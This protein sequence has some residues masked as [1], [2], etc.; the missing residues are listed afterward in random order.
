MRRF[1][2]A[3]IATI[4]GFGVAAA[5]GDPYDAND[6][7]TPAGDGGGADA[8]TDGALDGD[9][10]MF[11]SGVFEPDAAPPIDATTDKP[12]VDAN[13][14]PCDCDGD[15]FVLNNV[16]KCPDAGGKRADCD[17]GDPR[18]F[19]DAG[20]R[21]DQPTT[22]TQGDWNC[23]GT[24]RRQY[25]VL[26]DCASISYFNC[27]GAQGFAVDPACGSA[28]SYVFCKRSG[29]ACTTGSSEIRIQGC[30]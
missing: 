1:A 26:I 15:G 18:A 16:A 24:I 10:G 12:A 3:A 20:F 27:N 4:A 25:P 7:A 11:D 17:D 8:T 19:P 14:D 30:K 21:T 2:L 6:G 5:C 23:D 13:C 22:D 28:A 9:V 29:V